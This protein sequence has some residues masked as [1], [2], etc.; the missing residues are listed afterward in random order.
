[1][2]NELRHAFRALLRIPAF[3]IP[4][5]LCLALAIGAN[6]AIFSV[7]DAVLL[8]PLPFP[9]PERLVGVWERSQRRLDGFNVVAPANFLDWQRQ[10][11]T[12]ATMGAIWERRLAVT[13]LGEAVEVPAQSV[14]GTLFP[15]L[16]VSAM[17]GRTFTS[18]EDAPNGPAAVV[19]SYGFWRSRLGGDPNAVGR[20]IVV[21]G[22]ARRVVGSSPRSLKKSRPATGRGRS[23]V[24]PSST[25]G[26]IRSLFEM[27]RRSVPSASTTFK[28]STVISPNFCGADAW[29]NAAVVKPASTRDVIAT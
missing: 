28:R 2:L 5:V 24:L 3:T 29:R 11:R 1:M 16:G 26:C 13:G 20:T 23:I 17:L 21:D 4:A 8:R 22:Q 19:L 25:P 14:S 12:M 7:V 15:T 6:T 9:A 27:T 18:E 10:S